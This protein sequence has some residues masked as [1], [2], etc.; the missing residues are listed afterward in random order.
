MDGWQ[1]QFVASSSEVLGVHNSE[2]K[3][4]FP[5]GNDQNLSYMTY[6]TD[7]ESSG[8]LV[9]SFFDGLGFGNITSYS[10]SDNSNV[11][12][13]DG[14]SYGNKYIA[15]E[16]IDGEYQ[17][18]INGQLKARFDSFSIKPYSQGTK[19][20]VKFDKQPL[21][22]IK[23]NSATDTTKIKSVT[24][25]FQRYNHTTSTYIDLTDE[26]VRLTFEQS[27]SVIHI[28]TFL[29]KSDGTEAGATITDYNKITGNNITVAFTEEVLK[30]DIN[31]LVAIY[32]VLGNEY[33]I[34]INF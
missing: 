3:M 34:H 21:M 27:E 9:Q 4:Y 32:S 17:V 14:S 19:S 15:T 12:K 8:T 29:S 1:P 7:S 18:K 20:D 13:N 28:D 10:E 6:V 5:S 31:Y 30:T 26:E 23:L 22:L 24:F 11:I 33:D 2:I 16:P 25:K